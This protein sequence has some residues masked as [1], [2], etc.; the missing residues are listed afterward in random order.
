VEV[1]DVDDPKDKE[2]T[3]PLPVIQPEIPEI[4]EHRF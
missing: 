1:A 2:A 4:N 3:E